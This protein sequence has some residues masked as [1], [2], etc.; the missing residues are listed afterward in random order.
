MLFIKRNSLIARFVLV[1]ALLGG[2]VGAVLSGPVHAATLIHY[3]K[4]DATGANDGTSWTDAY[5]D[6]QSALTAASSGDEIWVAAGI[7]KPTTDTDRTIS[8]VLKNGVGIYGGFAGTETLRTQRDYET[9]LT[10]LSGDIG[11]QAEGSDNSYHVVVGNNTNNSAILDGFMITAGNADD[12]VPYSPKGQ[13]GGMYSY[14][15]SPTLSNVIFTGNSAKF[16]GGMFSSGGPGYE[17]PVSYLT[18][19]NVVFQNNSAIEGGGFFSENYV[20]ATLTDVTFEGNTANRAGGG[21]Q[22]RLGTI[23]LTN[24][25]FNN[26]RSDGAG[27]GIQIISLNASLTNVTFSG[28]SAVFGGGL[29]NA[30]TDSQLTNVTFSN[31]TAEAGGGMWNNEASPILMDVMFS[32]NSALNVGGGMYNEVNSTPELTNVTFTANSAASGSAMYNT[33]SSPALLDVTFSDNTGSAGSRG[34]AMVNDLGSSPSLA[35]VTFANNSVAFTGGAMLNAS[36]SNPSLVNV[37]FAGNSSSDKGG[38]IYNWESS[39]SLK[40]VTMSGNASNAGGAIYNDQNSNPSIVNSILYGDTGG[41]IVNNSGTALVTYS[42]VQGGYAGVGNI[43]QDPVLGPLQD[44]G[45]FTQTMALGPGSPALDAGD[46]AYCPS[47]DQRGVT[48]PQGSGCDIGAY[49]YAETIIPTLTVTASPTQTPTYT[50]TPTQTPPYSYNPLL[51]S[52]TGNQTIGGVAVADE[53]IV[54]FDG[55][56]WSLYFDGSDVGVAGSDLVAFTILYSNTF[57]MSFS[58][59]VTVH[60][61]TATPQDVLRFEATSLGDTTSGNWSLYFDGSDVGLDTTSEKIDSLTEISGG[62]LLISTT[63]NVSVPGLTTG[64]DEDVLAFTPYSLGDMTSGTWWIYFDGSDVGLGE[65]NNEDIDMVDVAL[66]GYLY[67]STVG[68]FAV[69]GLTGGDEDVFVCVPASLGDVTACNYLPSLYFDG[70]TWGLGAN[71][72][73]A[74]YSL[75]VVDEPYPFPTDVTLTPSLVVPTSTLTA[76]L[77]QTSTPTPFRTPTPR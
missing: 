14:L 24:V 29:I 61:I 63:G 34:G 13:G 55:K 68:D 21:M 48:R 38:A 62:H 72:V 9:N 20:H 71:D 16:G 19:T 10:I 12:S 26:N 33:S 3:V 67:L 58:S 54:A 44:N 27:G 32:G 7:Y 30:H 37:T 50:P 64:R 2:M 52:F 56:N 40:H 76:T 57:L 45:G 11:T 22:D 51:L 47:T 73:D 66:N 6:L 69:H 75:A 25:V 74:F 4:W 8:F 42:I 60:G 18:L 17:E 70:S 43:D 31:N 41:E 77:T 28:N 65:N 49:E 36:N 59:D 35:H 46:N 5:T 23:V 53:D 39:P 15:G 1:L